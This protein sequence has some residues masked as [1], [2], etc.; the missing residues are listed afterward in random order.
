[1]GYERTTD[2][3]QREPLDKGLRFDNMDL[4]RYFLSVTVIVA[5]F[6]EI[7]ST[8]ISWPIDSGTAVGVFFGLS[9]FLVY[10]S[11][12]RH[13]DLRTYVRGRMRRILPSYWF[14]VLAC[15][16]GLCLVS[17]LSLKDYFS[18]GTFWEYTFSN[19]FFLN[20]L[21]PDLPGVFAD[22]INTC[23]NGSL[24]TLKV[25]WTLYLSIPLFFWLLRRLRCRVTPFVVG[26]VL[27]SVAYKEAMEWAFR[28]TGNPLYHVLSYQFAGQLIYFYAGV[29]LY[30]HLNRVE[31]HKVTLLLVALLFCSC[32][33]LDTTSLAAATLVDVFFPAGSVLFFLILSITPS[34]GQWISRLGNCSYEMYLFH[35]PLMQLASAYKVDEHIGK[36]LLFVLLLLLIFLISYLFNK[37]IQKHFYGVR[38][39]RS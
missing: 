7:F 15:A 11:Y 16:V 38:V 37:T 36:P 4:V 3:K 17:T 12:L 18:S 31:N 6:N 29:L 19:I 33:A 10:R 20:F 14:I 30:H 34:L 35:F 13:P 8:S 21:Q 9:G 1:M 5:H 2:L 27:L 32:L 23:V 24:W 28:S 25:E 22:N 39:E 26:I